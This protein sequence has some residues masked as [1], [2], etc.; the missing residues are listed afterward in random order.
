MIEWETYLTQ[1][2]ADPLAEDFEPTVPAPPELSSWLYLFHAYL[3]LED[4]HAE[5]A[6]WCN[7]SGRIQNFSYSW[8]S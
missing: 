7:L 4:V 8:T 1:L 3:Q 5:T 6:E 2:R